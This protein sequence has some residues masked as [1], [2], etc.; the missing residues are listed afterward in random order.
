MI[1]CVN[2]INCL[3]RVLEKQCD[4][5]EI[6]I[7]VLKIFFGW[8]SHFEKLLLHHTFEHFLNEVLIIRNPDDERKLVTGVGLC[9]F[10]QFKF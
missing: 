7:Q 10:V 1:M 3:A 2:N 9:I 8:I 4:V 5:C 6:G